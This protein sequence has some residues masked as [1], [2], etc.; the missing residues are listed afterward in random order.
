[1]KPIVIIGTGLA[2]YTLAREIRKLN[3]Q[4]P[5][6]LITAD[7]GAYYSKPQLSAALT[8]QKT[9]ENLVLADAEKM[10]S[11]LNAEI[12][13]H[14]QVLH[15][16][17]AQKIIHSKERD[18]AYESCVLATGA[19]VIA[20]ML[21]GDAVDRVCYVNNLE[22]YAKFRK[23]IFA[24]TRIAVIGAG[25][26]GVEFASD[27]THAGFAVE[28]IALGESP[29]DRFIPK[30]VGDALAAKMAQQGVCWHFKNSV[31]T[32]NKKDEGLAVALASGE[33]L[34]VDEVLS[35]IGIRP[36]LE[37]AQKIGLAVNRGIVVDEYFKT[38][39]DSIYA[40]GDCVEYEACVRPFIAPI[41]NA[42]SKLAKTLLGEATPIQYAP[43]PVIAK[44]S[45]YPI[46]FVEPEV[47][48][49]WEFECAEEGIKAAYYDANHQLCGF[50][51]AGNR[52]KERLALLNQLTGK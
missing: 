19:R 4:H 22:D 26:V 34:Q 52:N 28:V 5:L 27:L 25:L 45:A 42:S 31:I 40:L 14:T 1:M 48:G 6:T 44:T 2:G 20:P 49:N 38:S 16:D 30:K 32:V 24:K 33:V 36:D 46:S 8:N 9:A 10:R 23:N 7:E 43:M 12:F 47:A 41:F 50:V 29:L 39:Q 3:T 37:L 15:I 21:T 11:Q 13:T 51:L 17:T 35:A 18:I